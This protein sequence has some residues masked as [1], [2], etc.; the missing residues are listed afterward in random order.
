MRSGH[1][2]S[3]G[4]KCNNDERNA[5]KSGSLPW[6][7]LLLLGAAAVAL[8]IG[9]HFATRTIHISTDSDGE[10]S[11][12]A[13]SSETTAS[14]ASKPPAADTEMREVTPAQL[15]SA[16]QL[17]VVVQAT[18]RPAPA[19][20]AAAP[21]PARPEPSP[22]TRQLV[23]NLAQLDVTHGSVGKEQAEQ[24]K[25][26]YQTLLAQ[27]A[28]A[29]PAIRQ[30]LEQN[31]ELNFSAVSGGDL[32]GQPSLRTALI[33]ALQQIG[34]PDTTAVMLDTLRSTTLPSEV[35]LLAKDLEQ[36][37]PGQY[38]QEVISAASEV[39]A[40]AAK[41]QLNNWDVG[42][43]FQML[44]N[45][46]DASTASVLQQFQSNWKSY[47]MISL[48]GL[49]GGQGVSALVSE[50]QDPA[51]G[52]EFA[53]EMLAQVA[54]QYPDAASALLE[55][56]R[57]NQIPDAMW[58][59]IAIG[60]SGDQFQVGAPPS[61][62][63]GSTAVAGQKTYHV[64]AGNQNFYSLPVTVLASPDELA[65]RRAFINQL[66]AATSNP[67]AVQAL[68]GALAALPGSQ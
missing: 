66:L 62:G 27:G 53:Y 42:P 49:Q 5:M 46:G 25:Q 43:L 54:A 38:R 64:E 36:Q 4:C 45:Y 50:A 23:A 22:Y 51:G 52:R 56:A 30:F 29:V 16:C 60:L 40:L 28:A 48:A 57:Q 63:P 2:G 6:R 11:P 18:S 55:Q 15:A 8:A 44:Q 67:A 58:R 47:S 9:S 1:S 32:L 35:A 3:T 34:G 14:S 12:P 65:Q 17:P 19:A 7:G 33:N 20:A 31:Q 10:T 26:G 61:L 21:P 24:W 39:L 41:G 13:I 59:K 37:A 68:Q